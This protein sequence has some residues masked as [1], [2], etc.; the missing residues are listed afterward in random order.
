VAPYVVQHV[1]LLVSLL[2]LYKSDD[3][4]RLLFDGTKQELRIKAM[5]HSNSVCV[6]ATLCVPRRACSS[7]I[8]LPPVSRSIAHSGKAL[9]TATVVVNTKST[10]HVLSNMAKVADVVEVMPSHEKLKLRGYDT[11]NRIVAMSTLN[12][13]DATSVAQ[14][15]RGDHSDPGALI[16]YKMTIAATPKRL[17]TMLRTSGDALSLQL[18]STPQQRQQQQ[19]D[20]AFETQDTHAQLSTLLPITSGAY[21]VTRSGTVGPRK[22]RQSFDTKLIPLV[23]ACTTLAGRYHT[24][25]RKTKKKSNKKRGKKR[26]RDMNDEDDSDG[27][28]DDMDDTTLV[29]VHVRS[30]MPLALRFQLG[31][32]DSRVAVYL[33][34]KVREDEEEEVDD[35]DSDS[36]SDSE[37]EQ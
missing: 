6:L 32:S 30:G 8:M 13:I 35:S 2:K 20:M 9:P 7:S 36:D 21:H 28:E 23:R 22:F 15:G 4:V 17:L 11:S 1:G 3:D 14:A 25:I 18:C 31:K 33:G 27:E 19:A 10:I 26:K 12:V 16:R 29:S 37:S 34:A 24:L 5:L